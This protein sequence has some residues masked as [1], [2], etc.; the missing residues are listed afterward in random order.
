MGPAAHEQANLER[1]ADH[2]ELAERD[3]IEN[4]VE[5]MRTQVPVEDLE[6][7][8]RQARSWEKVTFVFR[9]RGVSLEMEG[10]LPEGRIEGETFSFQQ[11][12]TRL[13]GHV[14][15][16]EIG[17][18]WLV[19]GPFHGLDNHSIQVFDRKGDPLLSIYVGRDRHDRLLEGAKHAFEELRYS[20]RY[21]Q[22]R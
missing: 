22:N 19:S 6:S 20:Y 15:V 13:N 16:G 5:V 9:N 10:K 2:M 7:V 18:I 8:W 4:L 21:L 1:I 3:V 11:K 12:G 14:K 17:S